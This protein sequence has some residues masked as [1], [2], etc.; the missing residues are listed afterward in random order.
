MPKLL[1]C[2]LTPD[3]MT[4][5]QADKLM[6]N[7]VRLLANSFNQRY[8]ATAT[9]QLK[10]KL[11]GNIEPMDKGIKKNEAQFLLRRLYDQRMRSLS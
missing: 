4:H 5:D 2:Y 3:S 8:G 1:T 10:A 11:T 6:M 9:I 7:N